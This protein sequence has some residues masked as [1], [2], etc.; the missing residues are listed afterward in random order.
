MDLLILGIYAFFVWLIFIKLKWLP[1]N[2]AWQVTVVI[3]PI[4][5]LSILILTLNV[6][7]PSSADVRVVKYVVQVIPQVRGRV[8]EVPVEPNR[9]VKK[10]ELLF[11]LDPT[12][13][14]NEAN[15]AKAKLAAD[16]ARMAQ[17]AAALVDA[18][19]GARQLQEQLKSATGQ[20]RALQPKLELAR[21]RVRQY[22]ELV[23]TGAADRFAL[24]QAESTL[25]ELQ[26]QTATAVANEAQVTQKISAR[27][28]GEQAS[29]AN[30][31][32]QL[33]MAKAQV[34]LSRAELGNAMWNLDQTTVYAPADGYA[35]NVQ[36]RP[37]S[38][39]VAAPIVPAMTFVEETYQVLAMYDQNELRL[40]Q[41]G[42]RA[43]F[44][45]KT[46]PGHV[47]SAKVDSIVWAQGQGQIAQSGQLPQTVNTAIPPGRFPVKLIV[48][49][50][51]AGIFLAAGATGQGAVYTDSVAAIH[52]LRMVLLRVSTIMDYL[53]LK[54]H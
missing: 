8:L 29:V 38:F 15:A 31:R 1:W 35:I 44:I 48:D 9:L 24:E 51:D 41:G 33:A 16:E 39:V 14:D 5:G 50:K 19:A 45:L 17:A 6:V 40:V 2:T 52:I 36:L 42:N 28:N 53:V 27:V 21:T 25:I 47:F 34:D 54:L 10:G 26:G 30:A 13:Y 32:A 4:V 37:G 20:V 11:R 3:I 7:A 43:E 46:V 12:Q 22:K 18:S 23:A 49:E